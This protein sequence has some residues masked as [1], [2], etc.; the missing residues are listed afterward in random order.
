[1]GHDSEPPLGSMNSMGDSHLTSLTVGLS[2][3]VEDNFRD[4]CRL[5]IP[6]DK[7]PSA[8]QSLIPTVWHTLAV[9]KGRLAYYTGTSC[10]LFY[11]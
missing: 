8:F 4:G 11:C 1:M 2:L 9:R 3:A 5:Q 10:S 6:K 7:G